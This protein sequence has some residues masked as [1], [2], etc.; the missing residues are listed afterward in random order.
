MEEVS[1]AAAEILLRQADTTKT[2]K[3][4]KR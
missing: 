4:V 2:P 1:A 3:S